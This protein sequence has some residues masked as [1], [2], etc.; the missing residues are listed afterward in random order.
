VKLEASQLNAMNPF[1][2]TASLAQGAVELLR[3]DVPKLFGRL[4]GHYNLIM[5]MKSDGI[6]DA[7]QALGSDYLNVVFGWTPI[8]RDIQAAINVFA[9]IDKALFI[10]DDTRRNRKWVVWKRGAGTTA[11]VTLTAAGPLQDLAA[12]NAFGQRT[13]MGTPIT[14]ATDS[15]PF[16]IT[17]S[18]E[19]SIW[20][21][22]RFHTGVRPSAAN[23]G[24]WDRAEDLNRVLGDDFDISFVWELTPWSWLIDWFSNVGSV[25]ENISDLGLNHTLLNY[26]YSTLRRE[27]RCVMRADPWTKSVPTGIGVISHTGSTTVSTLDQKIRR[28]ASPFGFGVSLDLLNAN[29]WAILVALGLAQAR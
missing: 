7:T 6:R 5:R 13:V 28:V 9:D 22:A 2:S 3:G 4:V 18:D 1:K 24:F 12:D 15:R 16:D 29:Q 19:V 27:A 14:L 20:T 25:L 26:A 21:T 23:N 17:L 11:N 10:S 8:I